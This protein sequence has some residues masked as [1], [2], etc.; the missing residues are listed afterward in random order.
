[1][2]QSTSPHIVRL[3][4]IHCPDSTFNST[5]KHTY[6]AY[7]KTPPTDDIII[8]HLTSP[9]P[10]NVAI[11]T[12]IP[13]SE[14]TLAAC[15]DLK[16]VCAMAIGVDMIDLAACKKYGVRVCNV[17][18]ASNESVAEHAIALFFSLRRQVV[19]MHE[20]TFPGV[21]W[22]LR[23][24]LK[25]EFGEC[26]G[27]CREEIVTILGGGELGGRVAN[28]C[29][30][31]NMKVRF[32]ERK[33]V[34]ASEV[35]EGRMAFDECIR[36]STAFFLTLPLSPET[37]NMISSEELAAM[38]SD[39]LIVNVA[40]GGIINEEALVEALKKRQ[41]LGAATDV[42][43]EEPAGLKNSTLV[44]AANEWT[45]DD[46]MKGR[47]VLSPHLAWWAKSSIEKLRTT[48]A[49]NIE[50]WAGGEVKNEVL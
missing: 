31:L 1:M 23:M 35:R 10:A 29:K 18:A 9:K 6:A 45:K 8:Q 24:S 46:S 49:A 5:F 37:L 17:P 14:K 25:D 19:R 22:P 50:A 2:T 26:P 44:R 28:I 7:Q 21:D 16:L 3:D 48:V 32:A 11:T 38:R 39:A 15:P 30:A 36:S 4:A 34:A 33:G 47:L 41:I 42:Y 13:I 20:L 12:R 27:T 43:F 40:R